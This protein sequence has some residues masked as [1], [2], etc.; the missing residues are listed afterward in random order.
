[1]KNSRNAPYEV[2]APTK[3][4]KIRKQKITQNTTITRL[5]K[6]RKDKIR[7]VRK[8]RQQHKARQHN[9]N[10]KIITTQEKL[11]GKTR[12]DKIRTE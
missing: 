8:I 6:M 5:D 7:K 11:E 12:K 10:H 2:P 4:P 3:K 9:H 1:M